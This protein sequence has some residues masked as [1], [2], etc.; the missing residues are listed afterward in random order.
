[1][2]QEN[3]TLTETPA[4]EKYLKPNDAEILAKINPIT[5]NENSH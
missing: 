4:I 5:T 3:T 1:M 2:R